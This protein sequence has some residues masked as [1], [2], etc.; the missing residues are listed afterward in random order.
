MNRPWTLLQGR[1]PQFAV[2]APQYRLSII[3][4]EKGR[5]TEEL[6]LET[7]NGLSV[8]WD[9]LL[10]RGLEDE[11]SAAPKGIIESLEI[12]NS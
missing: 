4:G 5:K 12:C 7:D 1:A 2:D 11:L 3:F 10:H 9:L 8:S 6:S